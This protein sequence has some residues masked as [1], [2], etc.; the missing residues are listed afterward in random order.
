MASTLMQVRE[1]EAP[2]ELASTYRDIRQCLRST[3][4]PLLFRVLGPHPSLLKRVWKQLRPNIV[5]RAFEEASDDLR[6]HLA[7]AA[8]NLGAPLIEPVLAAEGFDGDDL[9]DIR[10][11]VDIFHYVDPK[12]LLC[13][14]ILL[15]ACE[16]H[17][18]GGMHV[19]P[20]M[21]LT[22]PEGP[23]RDM[24]RLSMVPEEPPGSITEVF[25][26]I[27]ETTHL[28]VATADM[29]ALARWP[30]FLE[31]AWSELRGVYRHPQF[32]ATLAT[33]SREADSLARHLPHPVE[34][35]EETLEEDMRFMNETGELLERIRPGVHRLALLASALKVALDGPQDALDSPF[36]VEWDDRVAEQLEI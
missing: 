1:G 28:P 2:A 29:R 3:Y 18:V 34:L 6:A 15:L 21:R 24:G 27:L 8:V 13:E 7:T 20:E 9:E 32:K 17:R 30:T 19:R 31:A 35:N 16:G 11:Q 5:S 4:V 12:Q 10:A 22:I 26:E 14:S 23:P 25:G 36:P 33:I